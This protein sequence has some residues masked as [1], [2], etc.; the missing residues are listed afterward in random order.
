MKSKV[1]LYSLF[2]ERLN[3]AKESSKKEI[4]PFPLIFEKLCRNFSITKQ[5]CWEILFLLRDAE[6]IEIIPFHG[7]KIKNE[8]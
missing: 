8:N 5:Y 1:G 4:I 3:E 7:V 2:L 6:L